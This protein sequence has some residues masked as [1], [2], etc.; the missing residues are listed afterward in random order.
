MPLGPIAPTVAE[1]GVYLMSAPTCNFCWGQA[2]IPHI[3]LP[4]LYEIEQEVIQATAFAN[5]C[6]PRTNHLKGII[7]DSS[8]NNAGSKTAIDD[9]AL[10]LTSVDWCL[11]DAEG[12]GMDDVPA[13]KAQKLV[14]ASIQHLCG[15]DTVK[16]NGAMGHKFYVNN[17]AQLIAQ[18]MENP[19]VRP[20][21]HFYP[22]YLTGAVKTQTEVNA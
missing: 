11:V 22:E 9:P 5:I 10:P 2:V 4:K 8:F 17:L 3:S 14:N 1:L 16:Y 13:V 21:L 15:I 12:H 20:H 7:A 6:R 19:L 18:E